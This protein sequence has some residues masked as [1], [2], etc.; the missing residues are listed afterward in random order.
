MSGLKSFFVLIFLFSV[1]IL[2]I[3]GVKLSKS[4]ANSGKITDYQCETYCKE[5]NRIGY[6]VCGVIRADC[7][8]YD[9]KEGGCRSER[10]FERHCLLRAKEILRHSKY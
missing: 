5:H 9:T 3:A 10:V 1:L 8:C 7:C 6:S 2:S 4:E